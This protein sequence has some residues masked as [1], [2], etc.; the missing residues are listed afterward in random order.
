MT[1]PDSSGSSARPAAAGPSN[2]PDPKATST[3]SGRPA[4]AGLSQAVLNASPVTPPKSSPPH[5]EPTETERPAAAGQTVSGSIERH[6]MSTQA[7]EILDTK[8]TGPHCTLS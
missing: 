7:H 8:L 2:V 1:T 3:S 4:A 6:Y 5:P